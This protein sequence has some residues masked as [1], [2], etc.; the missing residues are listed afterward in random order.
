[1]EDQGLEEDDRNALAGLST[2]PPPRKAYSYSQQL[3]SN[4]G[5]HHKKNRQGR[6]HSLDDAKTIN[7]SSSNAYSYFLEGSS[8]DDDDFYPYSTTTG[9]G[10]G[11]GAGGSGDYSNL[12]PRIDGMSIGDGSGGTQDQ[13]SMPEFMG[14]G[15]G[16]GVF[17]V[18]TR[19]A[20]HPGRPTCVELRPHPLRE[21]QVDFE[22]P[23]TQF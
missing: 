12:N 19:A 21:T 23:G 8:E 2:A 9:A 4:T 5:T 6:K 18:P 11:A 22:I 10:A 1:M 20:V 7:I 15:G 17:K 14:A 3:R 13:Q 16:V